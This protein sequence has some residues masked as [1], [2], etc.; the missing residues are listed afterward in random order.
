[1]NDLLE[2]LVQKLGHPI[3]GTRDELQ[4]AC[5]FCDSVRTSKD[6]KHPLHVNLDK[7]K[8]WCFRCPPNGRGGSTEWLFKLL[9]IRVDLGALIRH[10]LGN[11]PLDKIFGPRDKDDTPVVCPVPPVEDTLSSA[12]RDYLGS[13]GITEDV[14]RYYGIRDGANDEERK[15]WLK[16][17]IVIPDKGP[18]GL[19]YWTARSYGRH[20]AK[21]KNPRVPRST[22]VYQLDRVPSGVPVVIAEGPVSA[23]IGASHLQG[24]LGGRWVVA[25]YGKYV[26]LGQI[27][28]L[29]NHKASEYIVAMDGDAPG[30]SLTLAGALDGYGATTSIIWFDDPRD[31]PASVTQETL[32]NRW[33]HRTPYDP[34]SEIGVR[35]ERFVASRRRSSHQEAP[36]A[37]GSVSID[38]IRYD[39][40]QL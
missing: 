3:L 26:T 10:K 24:V 34:L 25:T 39:L 18:E 8:W 5:P 36:A 2:P 11:N 38:Q 23:I 22:M 31:D 16:G 20:R 7:E 13:R 6:H 35:T 40:L 9:N 14:V 12:A 19:R 28:R 4:F 15:L 27:L 1:M 21:Y 30:A 17:R 37:G 33:H 29:V 32:L